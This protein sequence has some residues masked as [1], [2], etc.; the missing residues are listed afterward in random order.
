MRP[1]LPQQSDEL[2]LTDGG[3]ETV[4]I[5]HDG[6]EL[7]AFAA[8][9]LLKDQPGTDA[10]RRYYAPYLELARQRD[11][12]FIAESPTWRASPRWAR[13]LGYTNEQLDAFN[14][15]A[16]E[17]M[18]ELK[19]AYPRTVI[20]GCVGPHDDGYDPA[21]LLTEDEAEAY[22]ATQIATFA[23]TSADMV[24]AITMTYT[25]E[26]IGIANAAT[27]YGLPVAI[28]F[29]VETDGRL[30]S[31]ETLKDAIHEVDD[32]TGAAPAYYMVNCAH[33]A[34]FEHVLEGPWVERIRGLRA[35]ASTCSHEELDQ[36]ETLDEGDPHDLGTRYRALRARLPRLNVLG[37]CCGTDHRHIAA[38]AGA[39]AV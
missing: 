15:K 13:G 38:I 17:L 35:N 16:I 14:R 5:F 9:D 31:G 25:A 12:G 7:P 22:H 3:I 32:A 36:A 8:F 39:W 23:K 28:S 26:A 1:R 20:S 21:E 33:P 24:T 27:G 34:H 37:G 19:A 30:P 4:L 6:L 2:F 18:E 10:L 29:T 11:A